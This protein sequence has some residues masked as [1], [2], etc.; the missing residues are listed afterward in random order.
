M[1]MMTLRAIAHV[2]GLLAVASAASCGGD[3]WVHHHSR[4]AARG[5]SSGWDETVVATADP[6]PTA[7]A[8]RADARPPT[9]E[10]YRNTYYDFPKEGAGK[11]DATVFDAQCN[12]IA[13][14]T[15]AFHDAACVQGSGRLSTGETISF[16]RR[17][18][19]CAAICPRS[20]H[21]ICFDKLDAK[22][23]PTGRG[24]S[25]KPV[26]PLRS[27]AV[28]TDVIPLGTPI[29]IQ[30]YVGLPMPG[31]GTHDGCFR[32]DDRGSKVAGRHVDIFTGDPEMTAKW[33]QLVPSNQGVT[34]EVNSPRCGQ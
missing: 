2:L 34:V 13:K 5:E 6:Q 12:P 15:Q 25:G 27:V 21:K 3:E 7:T 20:Q 16:A 23:F 32:A 29:F 22:E 33:N 4:S 18:C 24:A 11:K 17:D 31:G 9:G 26:T 30:E 1:R 10:T 19:E 14:V 28:D 8:P